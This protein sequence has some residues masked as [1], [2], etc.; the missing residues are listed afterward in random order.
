MTRP[1]V[2]S[3]HANK[4]QFANTLIYLPRR[5]PVVA[6]VSRSN[7]GAAQLRLAAL[8]QPAAERP[9]DR[10]ASLTIAVRGRFIPQGRPK[11]G[12]ELA[13]TEGAVIF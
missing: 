4:I 13:M 10:R 2:A 12:A 11:A 8:S 6:S 3:A 9:L 5:P 1:W 7:P